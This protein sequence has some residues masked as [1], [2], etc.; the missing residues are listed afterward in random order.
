MLSRNDSEGGE[1]KKE[2]YGGK[3]A[4][5]LPCGPA[6]GLQSREDK[7]EEKTGGAGEDDRILVSAALEGNASAFQRLFERYHRLITMLILQRV[8]HIPDAEDLT[9]ETFLRAW[10]NLSRLRKPSR[11]LPWVLRIARR[12]TADWHRAASR[13]RVTTGHTLDAISREGTPEGA[14]AAEEEH[15]R[16]LRALEKLPEKYRLVLTLRFLEGLAP[17]EIAHRLGE[18]D[19]TVRNRIFR[20][21][22]KLSKL[23]ERKV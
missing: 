12:L 17:R 6:H 9:Q 13:E 1:G 8:P 19:G 20:A 15:E 5:S 2:P 11:F 21:L 16:V 10:A 23:L 7:A 4:E 14:L 22:A 3:P 18:P